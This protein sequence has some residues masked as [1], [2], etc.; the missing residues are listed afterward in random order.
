[1][2]DI[3]YLNNN[4]NVKKNNIKELRNNFFFFFFFSSF[5]LF[6]Y[7]FNSKYLFISIYFLS[8]KTLQNNKLTI[9]EN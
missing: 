9:K 8:R 6:L 7:L 4:N 3:F 2:G 1:M 5:I